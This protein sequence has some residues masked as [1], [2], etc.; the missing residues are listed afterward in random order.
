M[1]T[2][3]ARRKDTVTYRTASGKTRSA[4]VVA[5]TK[6]IGQ[7]STSTSTT[8]GT[9]AAGTY[10]YRVTA[11]VQGLETAPSAAKT[12]VTTGS[13][14][15]VTVDF[16]LVAVKKATSHKIYGRVGG[17]EQL[18]ATVTMPTTT[19]TD[20]GSV[21]P[22]G[23]LTTDSGAVRLMFPSGQP[24]SGSDVAKSTTAHGTGV[25]RKR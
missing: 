1:P 21:T 25:Y 2:S 19:Y 5:D 20:T 23:A 22:S 12:Q 17:S 8:G 6:A 15:T 16:S 9:L 10:S 14:S 4:V 13:T 18:I 24:T 7:P 3:I 11:V